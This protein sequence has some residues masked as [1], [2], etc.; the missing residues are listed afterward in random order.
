MLHKKV[1]LEK[2]IP[3]LKK[4]KYKKFFKLYI[5]DYI[6]KINPAIINIASFISYNLASLAFYKKLDNQAQIY[7]HTLQSQSQKQ[8][9]T[10]S[11]SQEQKQDPNENLQIVAVQQTLFISSDTFIILYPQLS[12]YITNY[13]LYSSNIYYTEFHN[14]KLCIQLTN[15]V[16]KFAED[17]HVSYII[18]DSDIN[19]YFVPCY[20]S[21]GFKA[22]DIISHKNALFYINKLKLTSTRVKKYIIG[23]NYDKTSFIPIKFF[24]ALYKNNVNWTEDNNKQDKDTKTRDEEKNLGKIKTNFLYNIGC[25]K[26]FKLWP[27]IGNLFTPTLCLTNKSSL[28]QT[29]ILDDKAF[30]KKYM[31]PTTVI[32]TENLEVHKKL[33]KKDKVFIIRPTWT[34]TRDGIK[35]VTNFDDFNNF[36]L[37]EG[38]QAQNNAIAKATARIY[39]GINANTTEKAI[40][41]AKSSAKEIA[42]ITHYIISDYLQ[43]QLLFN[44]KVFNLRV[45]YLVTFVNN[46]YY[47]YLVKPIIIHTADK[48][49][50]SDYNDIIAQISSTGKSETKD[51][52]FEDLVNKIG[53]TAS[54]YIM[55]QIIKVLSKFHTMII[56]GNLMKKWYNMKHTYEIFGLDFI[57]SDKY[58]VKLIEFNDRIGLVN[59]PEYIYE[60]MANAIING[61]VNKAYDD[62]YKLNI[63][64]EGLIRI[65]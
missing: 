10:Q 55:R 42:A 32:N 63:S 43:N 25:N 16:N 41:K 52:Y 31:M 46:K 59:Y 15:L 12:E 51:F 4:T 65:K 3:K 13:C 50:T 36:M 20:E 14:K 44:N 8:E 21:A 56:N 33:F 30:Y 47:S 26:L 18:I 29:I 35:V 49:K 24:T 23:I 57:I 58:A 62:R 38:I 22:T 11:Q 17:I 54:N 1:I 53:T 37:T 2:L 39:A 9:E 27:S 45:F 28:V 6:S 40:E 48:N 19:N 7:F 60:N 64:K 34:Y 61:T 5:A